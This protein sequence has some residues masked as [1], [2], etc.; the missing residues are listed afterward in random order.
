MFL[1]RGACGTLEMECLAGARLF[2]V[3]KG[4]ADNR[5]LP[6]NIRKIYSPL[7]SAVLAT[8]LDARIAAPEDN[9]SQEHHGELVTRD[10]R[11]LVIDDNEMNLII[12]QEVLEAYGAEVETAISGA[13]GVRMA[14]EKEYDIVFMD[15]MMPEMDGVEATALIRKMPGERFCSLPIVA[16][17]ANAVGDVRSMFLGC[18][19]NDFLS[20]PLDIR[21]IERVLCEW[22]PR[23]KWSRET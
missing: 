6:R 22:L 16:L 13:E 15:H 1:D 5:N 18:G 14:E 2:A 17:T 8:A 10:A 9:L 19:M 23:D 12:A 20:K 7:T 11:L 3:T 4:Y 21:E